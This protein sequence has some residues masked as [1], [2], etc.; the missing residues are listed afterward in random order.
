MI[1]SNSAK[2]NSAVIAA[3]EHQ[4]MRVAY[5]S[6]VFLGVRKLRLEMDDAA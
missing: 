6:V 3:C 1:Q 4:I 5:L 2:V